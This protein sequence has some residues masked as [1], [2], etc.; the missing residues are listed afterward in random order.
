MKG[1]FYNKGFITIYI[2]FF[3][4]VFLSSCK[5]DFLEVVPKGVAIATTTADYQ[6]LLND[7][8]INALTYASQI[9]MSDELAGYQ[10]SYGLGIGFGTLEDQKAFEYEDDIYLPT[11]NSSELTQLER[12]LYTYNKVINEVMESKDGSDSQKKSLRAEALASRAWVHF[13]LVNYY[14]KPYNATTSATDLG[15]PL[16]TVNDVTQTVFSRATVQETY[17][18][19]IED[20]TTAIP[21]LPVQIVSRNRM[22]RAA[23]EA[24]LGKVYV[25]MQQFDRALPLLSSS[26]S[27]L[28]NATIPVGLY[29]FN[30][31]FVP[32]GAFF[33][34]NP[35]TGPN[36]FNM[37]VDQEVLYRKTFLNLYSYILSGTPINPQTAALYQTEDLRLNFFTNQPF[38]PT[39]LSYPLGMKRC[40]GKYNNMGINIP[41]IYLLKAEC[42]SRVG[43]LNVAVND[44]V[45]FRKMRMKTE[46]P[47]AADIPSN[48]ASDRELLTKFILE[49]R[50]REFATTGER[51]WDMRRLSVDNTYKSTV[52]MV[53]HVY[54]QAG[55]IVQS[56]PLKEERLTFRFPQYIKAA[57]PEMEQNP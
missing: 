17:D 9:L 19:I 25:Y 34:I 54:D 21:D 3:L 41:D 49:E 27:H 47:N 35:F 56:F 11:A 50:I 6:L 30:T 51:W 52:N 15:V 13:T 26:I 2:L 20:L 24:L 33:P 18:L 14:G 36:R 22:S 40:Y 39:G 37:D 31:V 5:K 7:P 29:D 12:S 38:P 16:V 44:A 1:V 28:S 4:T 42:E 43:S 53:H 48:I 46:T 10:P 8:T 23:G 57:N 32:D 45:T 55:N